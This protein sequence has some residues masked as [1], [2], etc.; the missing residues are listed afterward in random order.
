MAHPCSRLVKEFAASFLRAQRSLPP[1]I[2]SGTSV[3]DFSNHRRNDV[4]NSNA[5]ALG[6]CVIAGQQR[7]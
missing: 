2:S 4:P 6:G 7:T 1:K 5:A 3:P